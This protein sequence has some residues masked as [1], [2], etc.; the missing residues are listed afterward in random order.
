M[1]VGE[2]HARK[3]AKRRVEIV[4]NDTLLATKYYALR[5]NETKGRKDS[6]LLLWKKRDGR[7]V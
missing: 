7:P 2:E 5:Q 3:A 1:S 6:L 4:E